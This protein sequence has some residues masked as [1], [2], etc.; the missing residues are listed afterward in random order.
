MNNLLTWQY[1]FNL[2]PEPFL[3]LPWKIFIGGV[4]LLFL[5]TIALAILKTR[6]GLYRGFFKR[7]YAFTLTNTLLGSMFLF[8]NYEQVPFFSARFWLLIWLLSTLIWLY[9]LVRGFSSIA[10]RKQELTEEQERLKYL[11]K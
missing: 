11:P 4:V 2:Q 7:L 6:P 9:F 5:I 10:K 3:S 1:W 8:F